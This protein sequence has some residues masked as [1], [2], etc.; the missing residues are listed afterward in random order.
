MSVFTRSKN[1]LIPLM[2]LL[3][4][5]SNAFAA[6]PDAAAEAVEKSGNLGV[7]KGI[8]R[9]HGGSPIADATVAI[10]RT[11]TS[12]LLKQVRSASD[13]SFLA[14]IL[15]GTYTILAV[16][17]GFNPVTLQQI[18]VNGASQ[19]N[20]GFKLERSGSGNTLPEKK[21]DRNNPKWVIRSAQTSRSIYQNREGNAPADENIVAKVAAQEAEV[22]GSEAKSSDRRGQTVIENY[23]AG[24]ED[25]AYAG[26]NF[27]TNM[28]VAENAD[29]VF[30]GQAGIGKGAPQRFETQVKFRPSDS[31][32]IRLNTSFGILGSIDTEN[33]ERSLSQFSV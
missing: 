9:D 19:L 21:L 22:D 17:E 32:Q 6:M 18:E 11:G 8:V 13:G 23:F 16:A 14:K 26:L 4:L 3:A 15:P 33:E 27:A 12:K 1:F 24:T 10:F 7:I 29:I 25:G 20:Y 30:A 2:V 28:H 31:H 5:L